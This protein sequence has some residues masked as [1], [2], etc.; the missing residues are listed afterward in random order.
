MT[1]ISGEQLKL[2]GMT[3]AVDAVPDWRTRA[4][5]ALIDLARSGEPFT[6]ETLVERVGL[7]RGEVKTNRN[8]AV[9]GLIGGASRR[10]LIRLIGYQKAKRR[11][12]HAAVVGIWVG[13]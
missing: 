3:Q 4:E 9:G 10:G 1:E 6:S 11:E 7:P 5:Q 8:N 12:S 13:Q 2:D